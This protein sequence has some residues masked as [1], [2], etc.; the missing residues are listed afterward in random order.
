MKTTTIRAVLLAAA[1]ALAAA[2]GAAHAKLP[3]PEVPAA[4]AA[5]EGHKAF[6]LGHATGV[7]I[8]AC[9]ET[10]GGFAWSFV[11]PR[12]DLYGD[13][14]QKL[15][16]THFGGPTWQAKDGSSVVGRVVDRAPADGTIPWLLLEVVSHGGPEDG[17]L[18]ATTYIQ[19]IATTGGVAPSGGCAADTAG[20]VA[21]VP[22]TADYVFWKAK[23]E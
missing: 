17:R 3:A 18:A 20:A 14:S 13:T 12:A 6:L 22:Y 21:E 4:I 16:M 2:A 7:Q 19:R 10:A 5:P 11:A 15:L 9:T 8:Y 1:A 23:G